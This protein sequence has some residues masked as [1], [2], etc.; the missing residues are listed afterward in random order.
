MPLE[1]EYEPSPTQWVREQVDLYESSGGTQGTTLLDTGLPVIILTTL[2]SR[3][4]KI[5]K[6][7][8]MRVEHQGRYAV[9]A[10]QGGAPQHPVWY[11]NI[12]RNPG[13]E[14]QDGP[15]RQ[16]MTA[17][18]VTG[19]EKAEWW[20]RAVA[21]FPPYADYQKKTDREIPVFVLEPSGR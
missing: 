9:V 6:T 10:S 15:V 14:L 2:G 13:V 21:A 12:T 11:H 5:R 7:P 20:Q 4:G 16:E 3:S 19:E 17:R 1:G 8:L 18:E